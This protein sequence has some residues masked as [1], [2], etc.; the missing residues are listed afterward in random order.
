MISIRHIKKSLVSDSSIIIC[1]LLLYFNVRHTRKKVFE[2]L[3]NHIEYP[4][5]LA[6]KDVFNNYGINSAAIYKKEHSYIDFEAPFVTSIQ[7]EDWPRPAFSIV[8]E[9]TNDHIK[10]FDPVANKMEIAS[11]DQFEKIDKG[12]VLLLDDS[13]KKDEENFAANRK[14]EL[15]TTIYS[16][17]PILLAI[18]IILSFVN[19]QYLNPNQ[20]SL[21]SSLFFITTFIGLIL[22]LLLVW[23]DV[24]AH[25]PFIREICGGQSQQLNCDAVLSSNGAKFLGASWS[26]W[27]LTYFCTFFFAQLLLIGSTSSILLFA[28]SSLLVSPYILYSLFYQSRIIKQWCPL[29]LGILAVLLL[30]VVFSSSFLLKSPVHFSEINWSLFVSILLLAVIIFLAS[31]FIV[32]KLKAAKDS[33]KFEKQWKKLRYNNDVFE[34]LLKKSNR[35]TFATEGIGILIG[36]PSAPTEIIKVCNPYCGPCSN[37]HP[38]LEQIVRNNLDVK[39]RIIFAVDGGK[40][41]IRT[42]IVLHLLALDDESQSTKVQEALDEWYLA[43]EKNYENFA[44]KFPVKNRLEDQRKRLLDMRDWCDLMR[45]RATPTI[46]INGFELPDSYGI[47]E[48]KNFF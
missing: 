33:I 28:L 14:K 35:V 20:H 24:D 44:S 41:D 42:P 21:I 13:N 27:G 9:V 25:N 3:E 29:C 10:Y 26:T 34:V 32:P 46:F 22:S 5:M 8:H 7:E 31:F 1:E 15:A 36:N 39:L 19:Y 4:S 38:Q 17:I 37:V 18:S 23:H 43:P 40:D 16:N 30:N 6:I 12:I 2:D 45:I 47:S 11:L 48:L